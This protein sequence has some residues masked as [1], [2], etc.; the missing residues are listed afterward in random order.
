MNA[1]GMMMPNNTITEVGGSFHLQCLSHDYWMTRGAYWY[2]FFS[3]TS[4]VCRL[5]P[6]AEKGT[7]GNCTRPYDL[8]RFSAYR[9]SYVLMLDV[10]DVLRTDAGLYVCAQPPPWYDVLGDLGLLA[11]V[12]V[13][14]EFQ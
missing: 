7:L 14:C 5:Q 1:M 11:V 13:V 2:I 6:A 10:K 4:I 12:G 9:M 3:A 8:S